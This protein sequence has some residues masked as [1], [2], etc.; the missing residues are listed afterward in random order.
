M[1]IKIRMKIVLFCFVYYFQATE[2]Q[3]SC[4]K[5]RIYDLWALRLADDDDFIVARH[6]KDP[7]TMGY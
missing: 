4:N 5:Q 1:K 6:A 2:P 7:W 3:D